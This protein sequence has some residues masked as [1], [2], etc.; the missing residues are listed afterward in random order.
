MNWTAR[1]VLVTGAGGFIGS[2]LTEQL[3]AKGARVRTFG[4]YNLH[5]DAGLLNSLPVEKQRLRPSKS[6]VM[7][8]HVTNSK[9][10]ELIEWTPR[11]SLDEGLQ[12]TINWIKNNLGRYRPA[13]YEV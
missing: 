11:V 8:L 2:H 9:A 4:R 12:L 3:A 7:R 13:V 1:T 6:E 5:G 10:G